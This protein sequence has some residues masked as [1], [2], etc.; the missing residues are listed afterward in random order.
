MSIRI[1]GYWAMGVILTIGLALLAGACDTGGGDTLVDSAE[2]TPTPEASPT[3]LRTT[4]S[5]PTISPTPER[6]LPSPDPTVAATPT[7]QIIQQIEDSAVPEADIVQVDPFAITVET[8]VNI[9]SAP[10]TDSSIIG[11]IFPGEERTVIGETRGET[12]DADLGDLWFA[13]QDGGF[14]YAPIV[15]AIE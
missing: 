5:E 11:G 13:L 12:V 1:K 9:R 7:E 14:V 6:T 10:T 8:G 4:R 3:G 2:T 15:A